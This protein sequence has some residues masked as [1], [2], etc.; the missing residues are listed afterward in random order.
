M[1]KED[2]SVVKFESDGNGNIAVGC[3]SLLKRMFT[4]KKNDKT[5][6]RE[7]QTLIRNTISTA[8]TI[9]GPSEFKNQDGKKITV[10]VYKGYVI[11]EG[12]ELPMHALQATG[13]TKRCKE[14]LSMYGFVGSD[15]T[16]KAIKEMMEI[17]RST[18]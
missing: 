15:A 9:E 13:K 10:E 2:G 11:V 18:R 8:E 17:I 16:P 5:L 3:F 12:K 7:A 6:Y 4:P 1:R 14:G